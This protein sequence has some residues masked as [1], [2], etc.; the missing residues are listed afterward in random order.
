MVQK[1]YK[2]ER[3]IQVEEGSFHS[4]GQPSFR[5]K[6]NKRRETD[7]RE[8]DIPDCLWK[9]EWEVVMDS[10]YKS[11]AGPERHPEVPSAREGATC[12]GSEVKGKRKILSYPPSWQQRS[13]RA[14]H[15]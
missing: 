8:N 10:L 15:F 5:G 1:Y 2:L 9:K 14:F 3:V 6:K 11:I 13:A 7:S 12:R 4:S